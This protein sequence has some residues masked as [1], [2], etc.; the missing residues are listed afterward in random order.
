MKIR[1]LAPL[2]LLSLIACESGPAGDFPSLAR[3]PIEDAKPE[4]VATP[5]PQ[6]PADAALA[7]R[8]AAVVADARKGNA[9]FTAAVAGGGGRISA[10]AGAAGGSE[11]WIAAQQALSDIEAS[12]APSVGALAAI[13]SLL[14]ERLADIAAGKAKGGEAEL[15]AAEAEIGAIVDKQNATLDGLKKRLGS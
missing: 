6:A 14:V 11:P 8:I 5:Q 7:K 2:L 15:R 10:G 9:A 12:R 13:E 1:R 4:P 3:R